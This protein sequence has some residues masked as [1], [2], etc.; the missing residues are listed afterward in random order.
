MFN[1]ILASHGGF[2]KGLLEASEFIAGKQDN[3]AAFGL[4]LGDD[5][6]EFSFRLREFIE[7]ADDE[8][9]VLVLTDLQSGSP[10]NAVV[11]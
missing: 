6:E 4:Y 5:I 8:E 10:F 3:I 7:E 2:A 1:V 9:G 11:G